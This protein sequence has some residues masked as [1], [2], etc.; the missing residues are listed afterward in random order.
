MVEYIL[1]K[2]DRVTDE[3]LKEVAEAKKEPIGYD[4]DAP[5]L[6]PAMKKALACVSERK[7]R[8]RA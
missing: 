1:K 2:G 8:I 6:S 3:Q 7:K 5:K 4:D